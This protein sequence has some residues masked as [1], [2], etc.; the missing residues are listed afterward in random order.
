[1]EKKNAIAYLYSMEGDIAEVIVKNEGVEKSLIV[2]LVSE[3]S[4]DDLIKN[5]LHWW[6]FD[7][8]DEFKKSDYYKDPETEILS[9]D[10]FITDFK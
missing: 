7:S 9:I 4:N 5:N 2:F 1:M 8:I 3:P 10:E 6:I